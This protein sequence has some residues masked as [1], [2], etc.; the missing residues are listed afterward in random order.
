MLLDVFNR[1]NC[2]ILRRKHFSLLFVYFLIYTLNAAD[3]TDGLSRDYAIKAGKMAKQAYQYS[4]FGYFIKNNKTVTENIESAITSISLSISAIDSA[5]SF[6]SKDS[7]NLIGIDYATLSEEYGRKAEKL[8]KRAIETNDV[9]DKKF[10]CKKAIFVCGNAVVEAYTASLYFSGGEKANNDNSAPANPD[11]SKPLTKLEVDKALFNVLNDDLKRKEDDFT[12]Q[13]NDLKQKLN[14]TTN[15]T[16]KKKIKKQIE[17]L[18]VQLAEVQAKRKEVLAKYGNISDLVNE[19]KGLKEETSVASKSVNTSYDLKEKR[20]GSFESN[21]DE[22]GSAI[23]MDQKM[24][25]G[26][27]YKVQIGVYKSKLDV[28]LFQGLTPITG[29]TTPN[30][31]RYSAGMFTKF[32]D[33]QE[34]KNYINS[35]GFNDAFVVAFHDGV[36]VTIAEASKLEK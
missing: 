5:I 21:N 25:A 35:I 22:W 13:I 11:Q 26:L 8:L 2:S 29:E 18:V 9:A 6:A 33:A 34:A 32:K 7:S 14:S 24:P 19:E 10:Y 28:S 16:E 1:A 36:K 30:G 4:Q 20:T 12:K 31:V 27:F 17:E 15:P 23:I 3:K